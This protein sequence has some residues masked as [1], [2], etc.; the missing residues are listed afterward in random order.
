MN[1]YDNINNLISAFKQTNEYTEY[2]ALKEE[3]KK[4]PETYNMLKDFKD[5][6]AE[7]QMAY[8]NG[9][10]PDKAKQEEMEKLYSIV[11]QNSECR[12]LLECE[13]RINVILVDLQKSLGD[14]IEELV[15]F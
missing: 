14:V 3:L 15:K 10:E 7:L 11:A 4:T 8:I 6:Q 2:K 13:M 5:K 1:F 9:Q 12:K